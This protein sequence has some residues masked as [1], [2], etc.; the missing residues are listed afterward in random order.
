MTFAHGVSMVKNIYLLIKGQST[1]SLKYLDQILI[2]MSQITYDI[3]FLGF[4]VN[5]AIV[6]L[7]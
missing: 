1:L 2:K 5:E 3:F 7:E 6:K 4:G